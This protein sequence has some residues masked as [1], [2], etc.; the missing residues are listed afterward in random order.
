MVNRPVV[1]NGAVV[2]APR[3]VIV[4]NRIIDPVTRRVAVV[5]PVTRTSPGRVRP[6]TTLRSE[7]GRTFSTLA[8]LRRETGVVN[9]P[10]TMMPGTS[11]SGA[12]RT[13]EGFG[14]PDAR[15]GAERIF[16]R[17]VE[18]ARRSPEDGMIRRHEGRIVAPGAPE[19]SSSGPV[20]SEG[21]RFDSSGPSVRTYNGPVRDGAERFI[22]PRV[23]ER[24]FSPPMMREDHEYLKAHDCSGRTAV[25]FAE[26]RLHG[27][28]NTPMNRGEGD[29]MGSFSGS[30]RQ[31]RGGKGSDGSFCGRTR[32]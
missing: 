13:R 27:H 23:P 30:G 8:D 18:N 19:R 11:T 1:V 20:R 21:R 15:R 5:D 7:S 29:F 25:H 24:S 16:S 3:P 14:S 10:R 4:T 26:V 31:V 12:I 9:A 2:V 28:L 17:S 22:A 6:L 32:C